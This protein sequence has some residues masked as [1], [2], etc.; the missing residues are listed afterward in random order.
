M[1][2][3]RDMI[4][5]TGGPVLITACSIFLL[6]LMLSY[7]S[8]IYHKILIFFSISMIIIGALLYLGI[9]TDVEVV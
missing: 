2:K 9:L 1:V 4:E 5:N 7:K 8:S 6:W 3:E